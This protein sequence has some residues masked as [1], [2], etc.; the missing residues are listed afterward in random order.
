[1]VINNKETTVAY[2]CP[3]CGGGVMSP[4]GI[5]SLTAEKMKLRCPCGKS[6]LS[7]TYTA[8]KKIIVSVP[9]LVC[10]TE[11]RFTLT[12]SLFFS[13][14]L[15]VIPCGISGIDIVFVGKESK[16]SDALA[17]S[18]HELA[19]MMRDAGLDSFTEFDDPDSDEKRLPDAQIFDIVLFIVR[20]LEAEGKIKCRCGSG[21]GRYNVE[22]TDSGLRVY[23]E[24]CGAERV[25]TAD[26]L[27]SAAAFLSA[28]SITLE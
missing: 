24:T 9:C 5:F 19:E 28:D 17:D 20:E 12:P 1:M 7:I 8:D 26:N 10:R 22:I 27:V 4:V 6:S 23:C 3:V 16:V 13:R 15:F 21:E 11:H 25:Y 18:E 14:D 2:R